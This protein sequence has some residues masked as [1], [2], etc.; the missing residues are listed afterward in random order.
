MAKDLVKLRNE[1]T[2]LALK[3]KLDKALGVYQEIVKAD[4]KDI[5]TWVKIGDLYRK[6]GR[7]EQAIDIYAK[8]AGSF[9]I[10]GFLMQAISVN[11]MIL[12]IDPNHAHTQNAL[13]ELYAKKEGEAAPQAKS[14]GANTAAAGASSSVL[15]LLKKK[16]E[17]GAGAAAA[18]PAP[19]KPA[20]TAAEAAA[21]SADADAGG[22][23]AGAEMPR[24]DALDLD[25]ADDLFD[26]IMR[27]DV[28]VMDTPD[29]ADKVMSRLP[30]I[31]LFS[32]LNPD[33]F[34]S[35]VEKIHLR[36][37]DIGDKIIKEG[38]PG[39]AFYIIARGK[40]KVTKKDPKGK[41]IDVAVIQEGEFF[42]EFA[43]F[44][45][46]VRHA[47]VTVSEEMEALEIDRREL[48]ELIAQYPRIQEVMA[49][50]Y[51]ERL[52]GTMIKISPIFQP[53]GD[54]DRRDILA[55]FETIEARVGN[56]LIR[57][58]EQGQG[59]FVIAGGE[60]AVTVAGGDGKPVEVARL[61]EGDFFG[62]ISLITD[63]PTTANCIAVKSSLLYKLP[64]Q[65]FKELIS[66]YPQILEVTAEYADARV[67]R[68]KE[69]LT[70]GQTLQ[71][72]GIV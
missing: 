28:V 3:G 4:P 40:A 15:A 6:M 14:S 52:I 13:A 54:Q 64:R 19:A 7:N 50:F 11:K 71:Q 32:H 30:Q 53:L 60:I 31:P 27:E 23:D 62:E 66:V 49:Q 58:G 29:D 25:M 55:R 36:R 34:M 70:G 47:S 43:F 38:E 67:K 45:E 59:L 65:T 56:I 20:D 72:A 44:S 18:A 2:Q 63:Q 5:K 9:A 37:F 1:A 48:A 24:F 10:S 39:E 61:R 42:G 57:Q 21:L 35:V 33:E 17:T 51:K 68:T 41:E 8:A 16:G 12:E 26:Q 46:S 69:M 22:D